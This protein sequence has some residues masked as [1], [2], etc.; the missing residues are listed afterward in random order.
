MR[1]GKPDIVLIITAVM[2]GAALAVMISAL[3]CMA[4][5]VFIW[6]IFIPQ[7]ILLIAVTGLMFGVSLALHLYSVKAAKTDSTEQAENPNKLDKRAKIARGFGIAALIC[8]YAAL[9]C[10]IASKLCNGLAVALTRLFSALSAIA[11]CVFAI[12]SVVLSR[13]STAEKTSLFY[14]ISLPIA[15]VIMC[16]VIMAVFA[17]VLF[18]IMLM[19]WGQ[20]GLI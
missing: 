2:F 13:L 3:I 8:F 1:K 11:A 16:I 12:I 14:L 5:D 9:I 18:Y 17:A 15:F 10:V 20:W 6:H 19:S 7:A 4:A